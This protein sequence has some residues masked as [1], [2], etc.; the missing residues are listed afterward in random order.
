[1]ISEPGN[2]W[3]ITGKQPVFS[4]NFFASL[5]SISKNTEVYPVKQLYK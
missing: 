2:C 4:S 1:M 3:G 5:Y